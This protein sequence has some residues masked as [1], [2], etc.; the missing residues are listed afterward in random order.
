MSNSS[1]PNL[2]LNELWIMWVEIQYL[3]CNNNSA[4]LIELW[5][6]HY[7][8]WFACH[9]DWLSFLFNYICN[10]TM[11][12][13]LAIVQWGTTCIHRD[14]VNPATRQ[15][16]DILTR[17]HWFLQINIHW[18]PGDMCTG[19]PTTPLNNIHCIFKLIFPRKSIEIQCKM[20]LKRSFS[21]SLHPWSLAL[22]AAHHNVVDHDVIGGLWPGQEPVIPRDKNVNLFHLKCDLFIK[23]AQIT[24]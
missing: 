16:G 7:N 8:W 4:V 17:R 1:G 14:V 24:F 5:N 3:T 13:L 6:C 21:T 2:Q 22:L 18:Q 9:H 15:P 23:I 11:P 12:I 10:I 19:S 20:T